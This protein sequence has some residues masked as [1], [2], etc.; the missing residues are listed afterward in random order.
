MPDTWTYIIEEPRRTELLT[1]YGVPEAVISLGSDDLPDEVFDFY[2]NKPKHVFKDQTQAESDLVA[3]IFETRY[4]ESY[5]CRRKGNGLEYIYINV[6]NPADITILG[7]SEQCLFRALF[8][9]IVDSEYHPR[10]PVTR[11]ADAVDFQ[12]LADTYSFVFME[13][14]LAIKGRRDRDMKAY[15]ERRLAYI[16][17]QSKPATVNPGV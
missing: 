13:R 2:C 16:R 14:E 8:D 12:F 11:A 4:K 7:D 6:K 5:A 17:G 10:D 15:Y 3:A 9:D 1:D